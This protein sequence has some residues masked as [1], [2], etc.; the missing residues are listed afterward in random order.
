MTVSAGAEVE[1]HNKYIDIQ[2]LISG[3][4]EAFGWADRS[5]LTE[6]KEEFNAEKD[7]QF[8]EDAP[9]TYYT[10]RPG[11]FTILLPEDAHAP[12]IGEGKI[13]KLIAKIKL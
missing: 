11:Q 5:T 13:K 2:I 12:I 7:I 8:F 6:P 9:Q 4:E 1:V 10:M 3:A